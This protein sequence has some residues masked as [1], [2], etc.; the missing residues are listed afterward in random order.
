[1]EAEA[2]VFFAAN[3]EM[4]VLLIKMLISYLIG[5]HGQDKS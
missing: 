3:D 5:E 4:N 2:H 1:M